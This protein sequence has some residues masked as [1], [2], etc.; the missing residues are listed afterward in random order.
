MQWCGVNECGTW[1][2][3]EGVEKLEEEGKEAGFATACAA[4]DCDFRPGGYGE[5]NIA[6]GGGSCG[7]SA[8][9]G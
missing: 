8:W 1:R 7:V 6:E 2:R 5:G 3:W 4:A 9:R